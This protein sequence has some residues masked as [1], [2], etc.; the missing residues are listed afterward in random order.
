MV[1]VE[2]EADERS[3]VCRYTL[4]TFQICRISAPVKT[5][6]ALRDQTSAV[7]STLSTRKQHWRK[8]GGI[9]R[10]LR[11][12]TQ[13]MDKVSFGKP[14]FPKL[15]RVTRFPTHDRVGDAYSPQTQTLMRW[16]WRLPQRRRRAILLPPGAGPRSPAARGSAPWRAGQCG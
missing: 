11:A 14:V 9:L 3:R 13:Q 8:F 12:D 2:I 4:S 10:H 16:T 1:M 5:E 7:V 6:S 15:A